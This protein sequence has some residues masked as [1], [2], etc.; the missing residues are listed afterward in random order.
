M[1]RTSAID[2]LA[3]RLQGASTAANWDLLEL[4]VR[5]LA[6]QLTLLATSGAWSV[7]ERAALARLRA[8]HDGAVR[9]CGGAADTLQVRLDEMGSNKEGWMAYA[10]VGEL[11]PCETAR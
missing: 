5:E 10:L 3:K 7:P 8:A 2:R 1:D 4:A 11:E 9:A 6:P